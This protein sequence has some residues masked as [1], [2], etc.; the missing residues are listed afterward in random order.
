VAGGD[1]DVAQVN[2]G[3]EHGGDEGVPEHV[4]THLRDPDTAGSDECP[5]TIGRTVGRLP[6]SGEI[7]SDP[8]YANWVNDRVLPSGSVNQAT[9]SPFGV[10]QTAD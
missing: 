2:A 3:V 10:V 1:L 9:L 7:R 6:D 4:R 8:S 5:L